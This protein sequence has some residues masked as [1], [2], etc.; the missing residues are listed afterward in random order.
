MR[1]ALRY[2]PSVLAAGI[3]LYLSLLRE[4]S[5][6]LPPIAHADKYAHTGMYVVLALCLTYALIKTP[7][8]SE[9]CRTVAAL[10]VPIV[11]GGMIEILQQ[12]F[13]Y[14][15]TGS[16]ADWAADIAG[17]FIGYLLV[18]LYRKWTVASSIR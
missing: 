16:W 7:M 14:P 18:I 2:L 10:S 12:Q 8:K 5:F 17:V 4:P 15:R 3:I 6:A 13:F 11:Y 9:I 1:Q